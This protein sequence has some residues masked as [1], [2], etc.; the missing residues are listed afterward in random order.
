MDQRVIVTGTGRCGT[1]WCA[2]VLR[3]AGYLVGHEQVFRTDH[4][5]ERDPQVWGRFEGDCSLAAVPFL[6]R[7]HEARRVLVVRHPHD[8]AASWVANGP[9]LAGSAPPGLAA[10]LAAHH[11]AV[12]GSRTETEAALRYWY[13]WNEAALHSVDAFVRIEDLTAE[14]LLEAAGWEARWPLFPFDG[15][16]NASDAASRDVLELD[17]V[18]DAVAADVADLVSAFGYDPL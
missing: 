7:H 11:P 16:V 1:K 9:I 6:A 5:P 2:T 10:H 15:P 14:S 12:V 18:P 3:A 13:E 4:L 8:T 17:G